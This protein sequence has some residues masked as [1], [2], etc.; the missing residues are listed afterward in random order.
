MKFFYIIF[1]CWLSIY[2][3]YFFCLIKCLKFNC[4][5][6]GFCCNAFRPYLWKINYFLLFFFVLVCVDARQRDEW[7]FFCVF[8]KL[9]FFTI[10]TIFYSCFISLNWKDLFIIYLNSIL[11]IYLCGLWELILLIF[12]NIIFVEKKNWTFQKHFSSN[13]FLHYF[14]CLYIFNTINS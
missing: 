11:N 9:H 14:F 5:V 4:C 6:C 3:F 13:T 7:T 2:L 10:F 12:F 8:F 1:C